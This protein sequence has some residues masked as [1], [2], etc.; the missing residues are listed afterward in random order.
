MFT[1][2]EPNRHWSQLGLKGLIWSI[3][4][5]VI[6]AILDGILKGPLAASDWA[7][8]NSGRISFVMI[9]TWVVDFRYL[10]EQTIYAATIFFIGAKFIETRSTFTIGFDKQDVARISLKGPDENNIV[11]IGHRYG[12]QM[13]AE[14]VAEAFAERLKESAA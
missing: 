9:G 8:T 4:G 2:V 7:L 5:F 12:T 1:S 11:W 13:E 6:L 3:I 10:T 14:T